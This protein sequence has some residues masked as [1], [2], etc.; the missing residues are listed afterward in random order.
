[1]LYDSATLDCT[2][3]EIVPWAAAGGPT[4][5]HASQCSRL[6][7]R[8]KSDMHTMH[9]IARKVGTG[10]GDMVPRPLFTCVWLW[11]GETETPQLVHKPDQQC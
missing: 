11:G 1:M 4:F 6:Q 10:M 5:P 8:N 7:G 2:S 3:E 9:A